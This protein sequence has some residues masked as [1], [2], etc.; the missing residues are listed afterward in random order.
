[1]DYK[2][3][4]RQEERGGGGA[5]DRLLSVEFLRCAK[6]EGGAMHGCRMNG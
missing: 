4:S 2:V 5:K 1:M 6:S 3:E